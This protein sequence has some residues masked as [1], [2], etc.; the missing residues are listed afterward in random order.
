VIEVLHAQVA[1]VTQN[2]EARSAEIAN[3]NE[4]LRA[5]EEQGRCQEERYGAL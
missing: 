2:N 3:L 4:T 1:T 5:A